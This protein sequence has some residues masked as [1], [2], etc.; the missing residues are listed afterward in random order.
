MKV[1]QLKK[2]WKIVFFISAVLLSVLFFYLSTTLNV[3]H[4]KGEYRILGF[5]LTALVAFPGVLSV[6]AAIEAIYGRV[7]ID[8]QKIYTRSI[9]YKRCIFLNDIKGYRRDH[10]GGIVIESKTPGVKRILI[11]VYTNYAET[12][13]EWLLDTDLKFLEE[14]PKELPEYNPNFLSKTNRAAQREPAR[15][16][17]LII[18]WA[19]A[20]ST[21]WLLFWP[22]PY[23]LATGV[24]VIVPLIAIAI[25]KK[26]KGL[27]HLFDP[28]YTYSNEIQI[29]LIG[30]GLGL[31]IRGIL[32]FDLLNYQLFVWHLLGVTLILTVVVCVNNPE[33]IRTGIADMLVGTLLVVGITGA[34]GLGSLLCINGSFAHN[35]PQIVTTT[36]KE[37]EISGGNT[38]TYHLYLSPWDTGHKDIRVSI[39]K[40]DYQQKKV[41]DTL[42][43]YQFKGVLGYT[44]LKVE[45]V[46]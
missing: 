17:V 8:D 15:K 37:K 42:Q 21:A 34:Y 12:W 35:L 18:N 2:H 1:I 32:D 40:D 23:Q 10:E 24:A 20:I 27:V 14:E 4:W 44:L 29:G 43:V 19:G 9:F 45:S 3:L 26:F 33:F 36:I 39:S 7:I 41:G 13:Y 5:F 25:L 31:G 22:Y 28:K 46:E 30:P 38:T 16:A 11:S 6:A